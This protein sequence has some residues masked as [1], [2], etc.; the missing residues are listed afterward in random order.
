MTNLPNPFFDQSSTK[1][2]EA[3]TEL[4]ASRL[5]ARRAN[6]AVMRGNVSVTTDAQP[7]TA[8]LGF[9]FDLEDAA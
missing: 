3:G 6:Y 4:E 5:T 8:K 1:R 2:N 7:L 9:P